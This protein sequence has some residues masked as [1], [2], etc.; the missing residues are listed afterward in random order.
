MNRV[1]YLLNKL[2]ISDTNIISLDLD[3]KIRFELR[4][5]T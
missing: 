5:V 2:M 4:V 1:A 3:K